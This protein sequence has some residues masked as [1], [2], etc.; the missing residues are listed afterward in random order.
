[1]AKATQIT[2]VKGFRDVLPDESARWNVLEADALAVFLRYG[3]AEIRLP[4]LERTELFAR[5]IGETTDIVEKEMYTFADRDGTSITLRPEATASVVR[6]YLES[7]LHVREPEVRLFY[8]GPMFRR[9]RPQKGRYRQFYQIGAEVLGRDDPV[10]DAELLI[11]LYDLLE[12]VGARDVT[13]ELTS[14]GDQACRPAY[15]ERLRAFGAA[16]RETLCA[17]CQRRLDRNPLRI[18]DCKQEGCRATVAGAPLVIDHLCTACAEHFAAV[19]GLLDAA[20][21]PVHINPRIVRGLDYYCRTAFEVLAAG[22][23]AQNAVGGG[24]RYDGLVGALGGPALAGVGF[25]LGVE[26]VAMVADRLTAPPAG[27]EVFVAPLERR[28]WDVGMRVATRLR[29]TGRRVEMAGGT[30][31]LKAVMRQADRLRARY[32]L[33]IGGDELRAGRGTLRDMEAKADH[34]LSIDLGAPGPELGAQIDRVG[35]AAPGGGA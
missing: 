13:V 34:R 35:G 29:R 2:A 6:A 5:S 1:M 3:F 11:L 16:H 23:G 20:G 7:G 19:R 18:L 4:V 21:V 17:D 28:G 15:R 27:P 32:V 22:L 9:E 31:S 12:Q 26:R 24:G 33:I 25:A 14:L 10:A 30:R 8:R